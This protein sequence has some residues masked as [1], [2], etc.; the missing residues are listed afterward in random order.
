MPK[1]KSK[2]T[3]RLAALG[4]VTLGAL[5]LFGLGE[6]YRYA[7]S[8][9]GKLKLA[10]DLGLGSPAEVTRLVG[11]RLRS[12][13]TSAGVAADSVTER[14][15][16]NRSPAV[17]WRVGVPAD[18]S[19][20]QINYAIDQTLASEGALVLAGSEAWS[21]GGASMLRLIIGL[22]KRA[23]HELE[24][25]RGRSV[26]GGKTL[27]PAR[28][29]LVVF[30][31]G[32]DA[33]RADSFFSVLA[34]FAV[35]V[36][37][38]N[39]ES[40]A[41]FRAAHRHDRELV[42]HLPLEPLNYPQVNPGPGTL[43]VSMKPTK[44]ASEVAHDLGQAGTVAA[45]ANDMGSLATQDM[46]LMRAVYREL[47]KRD[48]VFLHVSPVAGA[49]CRSL[50]A[51]MGVG[52]LEPD[53]LVDPETRTSDRRALDRRWKE[54]LQQARAHKRLVVWMR[55]TRLTRGWLPGALTPRKLEGVSVVPL[56]SLLRASAP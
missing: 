12:A 52:Y 7:T 53:A 23:T 34:P 45:V 36:A 40:Q 26:P 50:A 33:A 38:G 49:V 46:T 17:V 24:I 28:L 22:P 2:S 41:S 47:K 39:K 6:A 20:L 13:L 32:E 37:A 16:P 4:W 56:S 31:F 8:D 48:L 21:E 11:V 51:E 15:M 25:V 5:L 10:R 9:R 43:L 1:R 55:G 42:L 19:F 29:A 35:A 27:E 3:S 44:V 30:G 14:V 18:A 54:I